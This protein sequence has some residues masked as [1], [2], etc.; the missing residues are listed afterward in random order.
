MN[1]LVCETNFRT[2][3]LATLLISNQKYKIN[4]SNTIQKTVFDRKLYNIQLF[5]RTLKNSNWAQF[6]QQTSAE[7]HFTAFS[8][9]VEKALRKHAPLK[10]V[11]IRNNK[12][13]VEQKRLDYNRKVKQL[14]RKKQKRRISEMIRNSNFFRMN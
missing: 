12:S 13:I 5:R 8:S 3:H 11:Y 6:Y 9:I 14:Q 10:S 4:N 2:D 7:D 1:C